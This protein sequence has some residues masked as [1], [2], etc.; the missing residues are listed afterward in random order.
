MAEHIPW[1]GAN[2]ILGAPAGNEHNVS[3]LYV[4]SNGRVCV[5]KWALSPDDIANGYVMLSVFAGP[6]QPPVMI[7]S[8]DET[9]HVI[10]DIGGVWKKMRD[11]IID[12]SLLDQYRK[13]AGVVKDLE[14]SINTQGIERLGL[15]PGDLVEDTSNGLQYSIVDFYV[16]VDLRGNVHTSIRAARYYRQGRRAG[17]TAVT[18][19]HFRAS[20]LEPVKP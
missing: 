3:D 12:A 16:G 14:A 13:A 9:R 2:K 5:S 6:S 17:R 20:Q 15:K 4:F 10:A 7:G 11:P 8:E 19:S 18:P 1:Y